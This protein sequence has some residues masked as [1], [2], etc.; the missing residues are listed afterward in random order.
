MSLTSVL[1]AADSSY[2]DRYKKFRFL[3]LL[4]NKIWSSKKNFA[5]NALKLFK[6]QKEDKT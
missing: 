3:E 4:T 1:K 5:N 6:E 2:L